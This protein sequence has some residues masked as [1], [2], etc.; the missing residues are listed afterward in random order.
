MPNDTPRRR[1]HDGGQN[2]N[3]ER[4]RPLLSALRAEASAAILAAEMLVVAIALAAL[5]ITIIKIGT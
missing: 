4:H 1:N 2:K 3:P 5:L